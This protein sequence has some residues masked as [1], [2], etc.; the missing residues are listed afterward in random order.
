MQYPGVDFS[1]LTPLVFEAANKEDQ[2]ALDLLSF[3]GEEMFAVNIA[4]KNLY[5][6]DEHV[7]VVIGGSVAQKGN[8]PAMLDAFKAKISSFHPDNEVIVPTLEPAFE[9]SFTLMILLMYL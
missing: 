5:S 7:K 1:R 9:Q 4:I 8:H 2:V 3:V 6:K